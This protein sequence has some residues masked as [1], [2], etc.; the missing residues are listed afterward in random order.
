MLVMAMEQYYLRK[1][2]ESRQP[3]NGYIWLDVLPSCVLFSCLPASHLL[4]CSFLFV[5]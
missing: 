2:R 4:V 1:E 3:A 5:C